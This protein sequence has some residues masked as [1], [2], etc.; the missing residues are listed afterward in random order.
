[1]NV[2]ISAPLKKAILAALSERDETAE[3][4]R[5]SDGNPEPDPELRDY[6]NVALKEDVREYFEREVRPHIPDA[7]INETVRD[8]NDGQVGKVGYEIPFNR[9]FYQ[10]TPPRPLEQI[11]ADIAGLEKDILGMLREVVG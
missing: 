9:H 10:Y 11:E 6:E 7:W 3:I 1:V 4:C 8:D 2:K 5:D